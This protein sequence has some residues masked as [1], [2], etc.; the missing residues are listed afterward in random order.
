MTIRQ[1]TPATAAAEPKPNGHGAAGCAQLLQSIYQVIYQEIL[2][3]RHQ[4]QTHAPR[5]TEGRQKAHENDR[6]SQHPPG[7]LRA[8]AQDGRLGLFVDLF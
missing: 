5:Q 7:S 8:R 2:R 1:P 4:P 6:Q 3:R